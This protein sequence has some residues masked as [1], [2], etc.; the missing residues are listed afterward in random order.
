MGPFTLEQAAPLDEVTIRPPAEGL[1]HMPQ[2]AVP[3]DVATSVR[4]GR[5]LRPIELGVHGDGPWVV[6]DDEGE[7]LAVYRPHKDTLVK[8]VMVLASAPGESRAPG[9]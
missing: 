9:S 3:S 4:Y 5:V 1:S 2:V 7:V 6:L 8:P